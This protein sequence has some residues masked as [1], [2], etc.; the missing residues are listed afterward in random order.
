MTTVW[1]RIESRFPFGVI[2]FVFAAAALASG[3]VIL[4][5]ND[6]VTDRT[7]VVASFAATHLDSYEPI[8]K[9]FESEHPGVHV[10]LEL[11]ESSSLFQRVFASFMS[12]IP[13]PD[14]VEIEISAVGRFFSGPLEQVGFVD[15]TDRLHESGL[16]DEFVKA[17]LQAWTNQ[18]RI[19]GLPRDVS[20][21]GLLYQVEEFE[22]C[23]VD[24]ESIETW[25]DFLQAGQR[26]TRDVDG[27][28]GIDHYAIE[29]SDTKV[30]DFHML[31][32]QRGVDFFSPDFELRLEEDIIAETL[33]F[34]LRMVA[35]PERIGVALPNLV[36]STQAMLDGYILSHLSPDW[37]LGGFRR[38]AA[39]LEGRLRLMPLPAWEPGGRRTS[40]WGG[41][42]MSICKSSPMREEAWDFVKTVYGDRES[43]LRIYE[44][45]SLIPPVRSTWNDPIFSR[46][47]PYIGGQAGGDIYIQLAPDVPPRVK[48]P[49]S[50]AADEVMNETVLESSH[51]V[52]AEGIQHA[53][54]IAREELHRAAKRLRRLMDR[55]P[56]L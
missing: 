10:K 44:A 32:M 14:V 27:D 56:F 52:R 19:F 21:V 41:T 30:Q 25:E 5:R 40:T 2:L 43:L 24:A 51:R 17:K 8:V 55:N 23:G 36:A 38:D 12:D 26:L 53:P 4:T 13:G 6:T 34:Y 50:K 3:S 22:K 45:T 35:G 18:G 31:L 33:A 48:T 29:L 42:M 9:R 16:Y 1:E 37:R 46:P 15:L 49:F 11:V 39:I 28:G 20:P 7:L 54:R 47:D